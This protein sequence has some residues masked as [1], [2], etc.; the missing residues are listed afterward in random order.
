MLQKFQLN[1]NHLEIL[2]KGSLMIMAILCLA[3]TLLL[4]DIWVQT[5]IL[6]HVALLL[7]AWIVSTWFSVSLMW[8]VSIFILCYLSILVVYYTL[9]K[10]ILFH[11]IDK[12]V[13]PNRHEVPVEG[14]VGRK[15][16]VLE[17]EG[18]LFL[19]IDGMLWMVKEHDAEVGEDRVVS[20]FEDGKLVTKK[21]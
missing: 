9:W 6:S 20:S 10:K 19:R 17:N 13:A 12:V 14:I 11:F 21:V 5:E 15:S 18:K 16:I 7:L 8:K 2:R 3:I 4:L 1:R